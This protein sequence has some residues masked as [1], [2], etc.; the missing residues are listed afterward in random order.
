MK[1]NMQSVESIKFLSFDQAYD[2]SRIIITQ[3]LCRS[4]DHAFYKAIESLI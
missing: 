3:F 1:I 4:T 2:K